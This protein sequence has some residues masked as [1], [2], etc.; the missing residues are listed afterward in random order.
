[1]VAQL[2]IV[3]GAPVAQTAPAKRHMLV[4]FAASANFY[5]FADNYPDGMWEIDPRPYLGIDMKVATK[6]AFNRSDAPPSQ[7]DVAT[8][9]KELRQPKPGNAAPL[10]APQKQQRKELD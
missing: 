6:A 8:A 7:A 5:A 9:F 2:W 1:M 10:P 3:A 4:E